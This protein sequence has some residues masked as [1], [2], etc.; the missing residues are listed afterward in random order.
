MFVSLSVPLL[1]TREWMIAFNARAGNQQWGAA[2][3]KAARTSWKSRGSAQAMMT[4]HVHQAYFI[5]DDD[6][7]E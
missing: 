6:D 4:S 7:A 3:S 2:R 1:L 5:V